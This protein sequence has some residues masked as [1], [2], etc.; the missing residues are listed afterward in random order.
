M[1]S[2]SDKIKKL[3]KSKNMS[4]GVLADEFSKRYDSKISKSS[5]SR[6][7]NKQASPDI[8]DANLYADYFNVSLDWLMGREEKSKTETIAAHID[9]NL[10]EDEMDDIK[11]YIDFIKAQRK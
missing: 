9:D 2:F 5:I 3:R 1:S 11:K 7:E 4:L 8:E 10:T 6:W